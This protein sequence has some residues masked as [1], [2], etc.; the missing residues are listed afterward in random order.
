MVHRT[1]KT[2]GFFFRNT[3]VSLIRN[4]TLIDDASSAVNR[5]VVVVVVVSPE[6]RLQRPNRLSS[7]PKFLTPFLL[8]VQRQSRYV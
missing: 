1:R 6:S 2:D 5:V 4:S 3:V 7:S 8:S